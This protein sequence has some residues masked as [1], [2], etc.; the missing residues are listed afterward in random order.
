VV[1]AQGRIIRKQAVVGSDKE[2]KLDISGLTPGIYYCK[3]IQGSQLLGVQKL[4]R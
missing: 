3:L 2:I 4:I 1:D